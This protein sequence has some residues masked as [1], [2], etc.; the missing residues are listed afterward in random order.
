MALTYS[1]TKRMEKIL[2]HSE[3]KNKHLHALLISRLQ[4]IIYEPL[5]G[6]KLRGDFNDFRSFDFSYKGIDL[7]IC[8]AYS[9]HDQHVT[10]VYAGT[11]ENFYDE[12]KRYLK[13]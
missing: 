3:K 12:V 8:Y 9:E 11:R 7:R 13:N 2:K 6:A 4:E 10:F 1:L 5:L